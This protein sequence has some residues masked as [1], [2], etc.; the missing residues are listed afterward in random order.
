[1]KA[2]SAAK[3]FS[4]YLL[5]L[6][7][8]ISVIQG[9][10]N[11]V[12]RDSG[13]QDNQWGPAR[14][15]LEHKNP[16]TMYIDL[17]TRSSF[18]L[19]QAPNYPAS[20]LVFLWPYAVWDWPTAKLLWAFSNLVFTGILLL[21]IFR[22]LPKNTNG[23]TKILISVLLLMGTPWRMVVGNGQHTIFALAFFLLAIAMFQNNNFFAGLPLAI[24]WFK[25]TITFPLSL[26]FV[27]TNRALLVILIAVCIHGVLL[28]F[29]SFWTKSSFFELLFGPIYVAREATGTGY[30]DVFAVAS[31][32]NMSPSYIPGVISLLLLVIS[33]LSVRQETDIL[34]AL[35]T[36]SLVSLVVVFHLGYDFVILVLPLAYALREQLQNIR[37]KYYLIMV[38]LV[39]FIDKVAS[40]ANTH[41]TLDYVDRLFVIYHWAK[42]TIFYAALVSDWFFHFKKQKTDAT[43]FPANNTYS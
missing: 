10:N 12:L 29:V 22:L 40:V 15:L 26:F 25:Y 32:L 2:L 39:W 16:Y 33:Y 41:L 18:I 1:M 27:K 4:I 28:G 30:L 21:S 37:A 34:S 20:G 43:Q 24:S 14:F 7:A 11:A 8:I 35:S 38:M 19:S 42:I 5:I 23:V 17:T 3:R 13:S 31:E 36:L 6:L 9:L